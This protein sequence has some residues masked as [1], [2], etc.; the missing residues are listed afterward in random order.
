MKEFC[1]NYLQKW[2]YDDKFVFATNDNKSY[3]IFIYI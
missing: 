3:T 2:I 1:S